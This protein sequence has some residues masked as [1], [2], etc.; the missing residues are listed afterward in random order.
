MFDFKLRGGHDQAPLL[1]GKTRL[2]DPLGEL[3]IDGHPL[4]DDPIRPRVVAHAS[5]FERRLYQRFPSP[6]F[7]LSPSRSEL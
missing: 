4:A 3:L 7:D 1:V 2:L 5:R 6:I